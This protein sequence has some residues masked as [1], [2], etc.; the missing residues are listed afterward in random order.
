MADA[1][2]MTTS[3]ETMTRKVFKTKHGLEIVCHVFGNGRVLIACSDATSQFILHADVE[4]LA[5]I[6]DVLR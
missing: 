1:E 2:T 6:V 5:G 4:D 3:T